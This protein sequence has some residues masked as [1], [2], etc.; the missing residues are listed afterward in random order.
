MTYTI[1]ETRPLAAAVT[2]QLETTGMAVGQAISPGVAPPYMVLYPQSDAGTEGSIA[3]PHQIVTQTFQV[4]CVGKGTT[5]GEDG[6]EEAQ[7]AQHKARGVLVGWT[8]GITGASPI[9][10]DFGSGVFRDPDGP[11]FYTTDRYRVFIG[12]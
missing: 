6:M 4:T 8:P 9:Q 5:T 7:W 12:S 10:L 2:T 11:V 3:D 1:W